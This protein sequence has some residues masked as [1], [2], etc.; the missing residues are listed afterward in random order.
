MLTHENHVPPPPSEGSSSTCSELHL[1]TDTPSAVEDVEPE[2]GIQTI[3]VEERSELIQEEKE[4]VSLDKNTQESSD[5]LTV[6]V[7]AVGLTCLPL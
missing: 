4:A 1:D 2:E 7:L 3:C 5:S 6:S